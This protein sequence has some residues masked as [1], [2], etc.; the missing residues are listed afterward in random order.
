MFQRSQLFHIFIAHV[1]DRKIAC[2]ASFRSHK[3]SIIIATLKVSLALDCAVVLA[4]RLVKCHAHPYTDA[5]N[6]GNKSYVGYGT[7]TSVC[8][9]EKAN[10]R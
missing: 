5:G 10:T 6:L 3:D 1:E 9:G 8:F 2:F 7:S 4:R